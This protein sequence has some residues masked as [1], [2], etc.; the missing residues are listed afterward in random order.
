MDDLHLKNAISLKEIERSIQKTYKIETFSK[1]L[2]ALDE[3]NLIE[4]GDK[5]AVGVSGG[6]D[7]L[8]LAKMFQMLQRFSRVKF[9]VEYIAMDPGFRQ[10]DRKKL[11]E[12]C[13]YLDIPVKVF[14]TNIFDVV[15]EV[16]KDS[17]CYLCARMRRGSLY[18]KAKELGCNK[19]ALGHHFNDVIETI[20]LNILWAGAYKSMLPKIK[21]QNFEGLELIRP[22]Y[23]VE[24]RDIIRWINNTGIVPMDEACPITKKEKDSQRANIK[25]L[26]KNM[27][28]T[29]PNVEK[30]IFKSSE[31]VGIKAV[32]GY[33]DDGEKH[34]FLDEYEK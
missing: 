3:Y 2:K 8:L 11:E 14:E 33:I 28:K 5:I 7:S 12:I 26:I 34:S 6:K 19:L 30:S 21:S 9:E 15:S 1:F 23:L 16:A 31:N 13:R 24:E 20:M 32:L 27:K 4:N 17:P 10:S 29:N 25:E 22:L 18:S